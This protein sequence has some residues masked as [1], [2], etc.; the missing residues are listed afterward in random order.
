MT[1]ASDSMP[2]AGKDKCRPTQGSQPGLRILLAGDEIAGHY[3]GLQ[4]AFRLLGHEAILT[5]K[6]NP[7]EFGG[8]Y[9]QDWLP[10][11]Y[12]RL[13]HERTRYKTRGWFVAL[14]Y[15]LVKR[16]CRILMPLWA[17]FRFDVLFFAFGNTFTN[18]AWEMLVYKLSGIKTVFTFH[19]SDARPSYIDAS[20]FPE[21]RSVNYSR[22]AKYAKSC[23]RRVKQ[24]EKY[25][26]VIVA[27]PAIGH[28][29]TRRFYDFVLF[30]NPVCTTRSKD[31][32]K[33]WV[34]VPNRVRVLHCPSAPESKGTNE[35][36]KIVEH[37]QAEGLQVELRE[38]IGVPN[39]VV[40]EALEDCDI[41]LDCMWNDCPAGTFPAEGLHHAKP[42]I[43]GSFFATTNPGEYTNTSLVPKY[44]FCGPHEVEERLRELVQSPGLRADIGHAAGE[45]AQAEGSLASIGRRYLAAINGTAPIDWLYDPER[46]D[47]LLG[48]GAPEEHI[49]SLVGGL[50]REKGRSAL[51]LQEKPKLQQAFINFA[52]G[53]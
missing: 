2:G 8:D 50:L 22:M 17:C 21:G 27:Y 53:R 41:V 47:Y 45:Y 13:C 5:A 48:Y 24:I 42:V 19:G 28:F 9:A 51:C 7:Y 25:A 37:L 34:D 29:F 38:L 14:A 26:D 1:V 32:S 6:P 43:I 15:S 16:L 23:Y 35:I 44:V 30:G 31:T 4:Q 12:S 40:H 39:T 49:R 46:C 36:R 33:R 20:I 3:T 10:S 11:F 52:E 18:S